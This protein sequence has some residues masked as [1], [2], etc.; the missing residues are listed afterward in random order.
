VRSAEF[1]LALLIAVAALVSLARRLGIAYPIF[2]VIGGLLLGLVPG[3]PRPHVEPDLIFVLVLPPILYTTAFFTPLRSLGANLGNI[4][5]LAIGLIIATA[6]AV[7]VV[8]HVLIAGITWPVAVAPFGSTAK[9]TALSTRRRTRVGGMWT[10]WLALEP[11]VH[12]P[13]AQRVAVDL[14]EALHVG[15]VGD[16]A[17]PHRQP[18]V[19]RLVG[20]VSLDLVV[21]PSGT[22]GDVRIVQSTDARFDDEAIKAAKKWKFAPVTKDGQPASIIVTLVLEFRMR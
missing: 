20:E 16:V 14:L 2:L 6:A 19:I 1:V 13:T 21:L 12:E 5:S 11:D 8:A 22:V 9:H 18:D 3:L 7:A 17:R 4:S 15:G 10:G